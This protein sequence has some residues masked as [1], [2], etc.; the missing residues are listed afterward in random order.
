MGV[1]TSEV[2]YTS[3][4]T[5]SGDHEVHKGHVVA[6]AK[7]NSVYK[8]V[9]EKNKFI[10][11]THT[12]THARSSY[13]STSTLFFNPQVGKYFK[14]YRQV[15]SLCILRRVLTAAYSS[16]SRNQRQIFFLCFSF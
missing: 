7:N 4:T 9:T 16:S 15:L 11:H 3:A 8:T 14:L 10:S 12:H 6:V 1:P 2:G 13:N 5:G